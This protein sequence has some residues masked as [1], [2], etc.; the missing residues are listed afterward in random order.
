[1]A[2]RSSRVSKTGPTFLQRAR[3]VPA[4]QKARFHQVLGAGRSGVLRPFLGLTAPEEAEIDR[5][6]TALLDQRIQRS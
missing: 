1:M 4:E 6:L 3:Q 5:R 2:K